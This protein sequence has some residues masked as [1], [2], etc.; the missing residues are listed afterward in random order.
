MRNYLKNIII[1]V[2][3]IYAISFNRIYNLFILY[4]IMIVIYIIY[5]VEVIL[6]IQFYFIPFRLIFIY[7]IKHNNRMSI[8]ILLQIDSDANYNFTLF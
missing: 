3:V 5:L 7:H 8:V 6:V 1:V 2:I 4:Y